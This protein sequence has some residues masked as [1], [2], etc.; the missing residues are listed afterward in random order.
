MTPDPGTDDV[1]RR[2]LRESRVRTVARL[3]A[4]VTDLVALPGGLSLRRPNGAA[5]AS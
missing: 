3:G 4:P 1:L 5:F 2:A